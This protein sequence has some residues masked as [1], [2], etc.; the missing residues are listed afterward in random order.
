MSC[1]LRVIAGPNGSGKSSVFEIV[2]NYRDESGRAIS[3]GPFVNADQ[4]DKTLREQGF[5]QLLDYSIE[6][7]DSS[8]IDYYLS[9]S[10]LKDPYDPAI[11]KKMIRVEDT[12]LRILPGPISPYL[13]MIV[14]D[15]IREELLKRRVSFT[16]E[17][18]FSHTDKLKFME[19]AQA[20]GYKVYLYFVSTE[21]PEINI[22]RVA[23][24][25][26]AG[27]HDVP[28]QKILSRYDRTMRNLHAALKIA[29][30]AYL[31]DNSGEITVKIAEKFNDGT[32]YL[33]ERVPG[34]GLKYIQAK[35]DRS[36]T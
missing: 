19:R 34:W 3:T 24:R 22:L 13:G 15:L 25:V 16:M 29:Y 6:A 31:F 11:I 12:R 32:V 5:I 33:E 14:A 7:A 2:R 20:A 21:S 10:T 18:V 17:T 30:R 35:E 27:G 1:R 28:S 9:I 23:G 36:Q 26:A 4:I 8:I